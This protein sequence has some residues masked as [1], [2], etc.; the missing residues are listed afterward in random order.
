M[1]GVMIGAWP[2]KAMDAKAVL[3]VAPAWQSHPPS[4]ATEVSMPAA[5]ARNP[6]I[7]PNSRKF[8]ATF[9]NKWKLLEGL[10]EGN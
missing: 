4:A 10:P 9:C 2:W 7:S 1:S 5:G 8:F 3:R 6:L